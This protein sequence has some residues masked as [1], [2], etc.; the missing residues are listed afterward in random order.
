MDA[1]EDSHDVLLFGIWSFEA[2]V[3]VFSYV[4]VGGTLEV[5]K[6]ACTKLQRTSN[7]TLIDRLEFDL[8]Y[9]RGPAKHPSGFR[10]QEWHF[11]SQL[12]EALVHKTLLLY[13]FIS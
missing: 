13:S 8:T 7:S 1:I 3:S 12:S 6:Q 9:H 5:L 11:C 4:C 2:F 10:C